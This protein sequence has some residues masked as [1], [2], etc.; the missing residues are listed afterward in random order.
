TWRQRAKP[1]LTT[2]QG[3]LCVG[4]PAS[5][6]ARVMG[7]KATLNIK[8]STLDI[9]RDE[10]EYAI[11]MEDAEAMLAHLCE[12]HI[13]EKTRYHVEHAGMTWEV[14][15]FEGVNQG[16]VVA[17]IEL[18]AEDQPFENPPWAGT[19]VSGDV[20]YFNSYLSRHPYSEW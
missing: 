14:D 12:G 10:F 13:I 9:A 18:E 3:Y 2:R 6:R 20:R 19:E 7:D 5:V 17:E 4:P 8:R 11:A 15:V 1:G 16:L